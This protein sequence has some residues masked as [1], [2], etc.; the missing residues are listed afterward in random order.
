MQVVRKKPYF[1]RGVLDLVWA[2]KRSC[3]S[4]KSELSIMPRGSWCQV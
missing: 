4:S 1:Y 3:W 2:D